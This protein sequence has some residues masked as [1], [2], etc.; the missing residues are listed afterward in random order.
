MGPKTGVGD[1]SNFA[2]L[3]NV[4]QTLIKQ[5]HSKKQI[6]K[7]WKR[8]VAL[9]RRWCCCWWSLLPEML[10]KHL[11]VIRSLSCGKKFTSQQYVPRCH[12]ANSFT[13]YLDENVPDYIRKEYRSPNSCDLSLLDF[14][15]WNTMKKMLCKNLKWYEDIEGLSAAISYVWDRLKKKSSIFQSTNGGC[16]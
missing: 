16:D 1:F 6:C 7:D 11:Y 5:L 2:K 8:L 10:N 12:T 15:I 4:N 13:S 3:L 9:C 14:M